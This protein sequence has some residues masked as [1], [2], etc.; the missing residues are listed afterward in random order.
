M[1]EIFGFDIELEFSF[2]TGFSVT[3]ILFLLFFSNRHS[4]MRESILFDKVPEET[5]FSSSRREL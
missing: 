2:S 4:M 3:K 1:T 5:L